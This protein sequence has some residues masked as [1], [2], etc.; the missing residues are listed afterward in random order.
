M[1]VR[2]EPPGNKI[3]YAL[4]P[5]TNISKWK[6]RAAGYWEGNSWPNNETQQLPG[7]DYEKGNRVIQ[8]TFGF[9]PL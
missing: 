4:I 1:I 5:G 2:I 6:L 8:N 3:K 7:Q 9:W